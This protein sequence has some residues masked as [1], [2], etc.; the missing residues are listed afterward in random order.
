MPAQ[1]R[2]SRPDVIAN[3]VFLAIPWKSVRPK[4]EHCVDFLRLRSP[5]SFVIVGRSDKQDAEDLL[6]V[7]KDR[8]QSSSFAVFDATGGNAAMLM[9][10]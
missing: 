9:Y 6:Q 5:L 1:S 3:Q 7:I 4:Y 10:R 2:P 8:L